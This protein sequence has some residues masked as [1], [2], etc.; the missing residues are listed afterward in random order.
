MPASRPNFPTPPTPLIGREQEVAA[1][2]QL[3]KRGDVRLVTLTG[4]GGVGKTRLALQTALDSASG[5][6]DGVSFVSLA[7]ITV[8]TLVLPTIAQ[9]L[10]VRPA[11]GRGARPL[12]EQLTAFLSGERL[13]ALD[14]FE[15]ITAAAPQLSELLAACPNLK[16]L[17]TSRASLRLAGE[18]EFPVP[19]LP[20]AEAV[21]LFNQRAQAIKPDF[22]Q[23]G[24]NA[25]AIADI[26]QRLDGLPLAIELAAARVKLLPPKAMLS[27]LES[28][29]SLLTDGPRDLPARHQSLREALDW[30]YNL[31]ELGEQRLFRRLGVFVG[32]C[33]LE[34]AEA[35]C[36]PPDELPLNILS[37]AQA[38]IDQS[39]L[40][41][42][43]SPDGE[44]RLWMLETVREYA[45]DQLTASG[46]A[47][48]THRAHAQHYL[49]LAQTAE[50]H[51]VGSQQR[52][53]LDR[54][55]REHN[56][57]RAA[58]RWATE[59]EDNAAIEMGLLLGA[60][61]GRF[62]TYRGHLTEGRDRL[63]KL[64]ARPGAE[65][66]TLQPVRARA[67][68]AAGLL[69]IRRSDYAQAQQLLE[70]S[71]AL[72]RAQGNAGRRGAAIALD[73]LGWVAS[74]FGQFE[75]AHELYEA[76]LKIH[77]ELGTAHDTEAADALAHLGMAA[78]FD[79]DHARARPLLEESLNIKRALG[80]KWGA[81]F[82]LFHL[83][84]V[85]ISQSRYTEAQTHITDGLAICAE[86]NE[87]LLRAF[88]L[89]ALAWLTLAAPDKKDAARAAQIVGTAEALRETLSAP[90][91][92]QW[93]ILFEHILAD[94]K[95]ALGADAFANE[96]ATGQRL[97]PDDA[98]AVFERATPA[99]PRTSSPLTPSP[100]ELDVLRLVAA[101]LSDAQIAQ[102]LVVSVRTVNAHL[103]SI[104]NKLGVNSRTAA[105]RAAIEQKLV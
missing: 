7:P 103:Q 21:A 3:L 46:E 57:L 15:Q 69:A 104:Y 24:Q 40:R 70:T 45:L 6:P 78:F 80:E 63:E 97:T 25:D 16:I 48:T 94:V 82:A 95:T 62:W 2:R 83:G 91:P 19:P 27:R 26:C 44:P 31:L 87:R 56:N 30:S 39:L 74:A 72:W 64:L 28:R 52:L 49:A 41:Q 100:R 8:S 66:V 89:E 85:A 47:Q 105:V 60:A 84:C 58:L 13:L 1:L 23:T 20:A 34:A 38:L 99:T 9:T 67:L 79:N 54:L 96:L 17:V 50:P 12:L 92:P 53:W 42:E 4:P 75:H 101:G 81:G 32:G 65:H 11:L 33:L 10:G 88:L 29:L 43:E 93:R 36:N 76:S 73:S 90:R 51:L 61:L 59:S 77:R 18:H 98:L 55:E 68:N 14:N 35:V 5:Y 102:K 22:N 71:L 37:Q 86:L